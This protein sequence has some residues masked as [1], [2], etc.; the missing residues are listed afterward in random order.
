MSISNMQS[1][2]YSNSKEDGIVVS[3]QEMQKFEEDLVE[4]MKND[5]T[6]QDE[7]KSILKDNYTD[8]STEQVLKIGTYQTR[9]VS[10]SA[11]KKSIKAVA[12]WFKRNGMKVW[13]KLPSKVQKY[14][15]AQGASGFINKL[16]E[17]VD[18]YTDI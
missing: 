10:S 16:G 2:V 15:A 3:D 7:L 5:K 6:L 8:Y 1:Q 13:N 9:S 11:V 18:A 17:V 12:S 14:I 4:I